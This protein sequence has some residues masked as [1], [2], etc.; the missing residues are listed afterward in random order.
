V[1]VLDTHVWLWWLSEP[2]LLSRTAAAA[3]ENADRIVI[4]SISC[5]EVA[6][7][8][9]KGRISLDR[10]VLEWIEDAITVARM[11]LAPLTPKIAVKATQL[12]R[13]H[14]DPADRLIVA[15][16]MMETATLI[17]KDRRIRNYPGVPT[18]W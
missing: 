11:E 18:T 15:T 1:I 10:D 14:G 4:S 2:S 17:T 13:F 7:A 6:T 16:A 8:V 12:G 9:A 5:F 3:I